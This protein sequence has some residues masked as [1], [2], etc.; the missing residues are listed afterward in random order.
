MNIFHRKRVLPVPKYP[1]ELYAPAV[2]SSICTGEKVAG[3]QNRE[4]GKF[5]E[6][7]LLRSPSDLY[8]FCR[9]YGADPSDVRTIY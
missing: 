3:F 1:S 2:R 5:T 8:E 7:L 6:I 9:E 4:T